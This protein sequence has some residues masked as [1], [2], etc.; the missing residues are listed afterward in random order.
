MAEKLLGF[1]V[2]ANDKIVTQILLEAGASPMA[3]F[4]LFSEDAL[5]AAIKLN[6]TK[7]LPLLICA[8]ARE[9]CPIAQLAFEEVEEVPPKRLVKLSLETSQPHVAMKLLKHYHPPSSDNVLF[10]RF[11]NV[12]LL[13][14]ALENCDAEIVELVLNYEAGRKFQLVLQNIERIK[15]AGCGGFRK[16]LPYAA[17]SGNRQLVEEL[18]SQGAQ[19]DDTT[20]SGMSC[21]QVVDMNDLP[22]VQYLLDCGAN[23]NSTDMGCGTPLHYAARSGN[24]AA[25]KLL[26]DHGAKLGAIS[27]SLCSQDSLVRDAIRS[28]NVAVVEEIL[29][30]GAVADVWINEPCATPLQLASYQGSIDIVMLLLSHNANINSPPG[31]WLAQP[32]KCGFT[33]LTGALH[34]RDI[35]LISYLL[36][37]GADVNNPPA[38]HEAPSPL[39]TCIE[40][41][42][43]NMTV[44]LLRRGANP[45]DSGSIWTAVRKADLGIVNLLLDQNRKLLS[46]NRLSQGAGFTDYGCAALCEAVLRG[47][48]ELVCTLLEAGV[49]FKRPPT[50]IFHQ[51]IIVASRVNF[52]ESPSMSAILAA[53]KTMNLNLLQMFLSQGSHNLRENLHGNSELLL[54]MHS[55]PCEHKDV[56]QILKL[57]NPTVH[58]VN[59]YCPY[60]KDQASTILQKAIRNGCCLSVVNYLLSIGADINSPAV[61]KFGRTALQ[62]AV[63]RNR[64]DIVE[65]LIHK[66][67]FINADPAV[68]GGATALQLAAM[69]GNFK[70]VQLLLDAGADVL[71]PKGKRYGRT[72]IEGAAERGHLDMVLYLLHLANDVEGVDFEH[73]LCRA[74]RLALNRGHIALSEVISEHQKDK[75]GRLHCEGIERL[76]TCFDYGT[77][78][79]L[80]RGSEYSEDDNKW[81]ETGVPI[82]SSANSSLLI[83]GLNINGM[84]EFEEKDLSTNHDSQNIYNI[85]IH[86]NCLKT[87]GEEAMQY[88]IT[89]NHQIAAENDSS[90][91]DSTITLN[92]ERNN[93]LMLGSDPVPTDY[94]AD[95][96]DIPGSM[97]TPQWDESEVTEKCQTA[98]DNDPN[99]SGSAKTS[100]QER[101]KNPDTTIVDTNPLPNDYL[102]DFVDIPG[103]MSTLQWNEFDIFEDLNMSEQATR[104]RLL[105]G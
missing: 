22:M 14:Y 59:S 71:A 78:A 73:Q 55:I 85:P 43:Y 17:R 70:I 3:L 67:A 93:D 23:P 88:E 69:I 15:N 86:S 21:L 96:H 104:E 50:R 37:H 26:F 63:E 77:F 45:E 53:I 31:K 11:Y 48:Y 10:H 66:G 75:F 18:L 101:E 100:N 13:C 54:A 56:L 44:Q 35:Q 105:L 38:E 12:S 42:D 29:K 32:F 81:S 47:K 6:R 25:V 4:G 19:I 60:L 36:D 76:G 51:A 27:G 98:T 82:T 95:F 34:S 1:A 92:Q 39:Q 68:E 87:L 61:G 8:G 40:F 5:S 33:A 58:E 84:P 57:I 97:A 46:Q 9:D 2:R 65:I 16:C 74:S 90:L 94:L 49:D 62:A 7:L 28:G 89:E 72:A 41:L 30:V 83:R 64:D 24:L 20:S 99:L 79:E 80:D 102:P 52:F 103:S 91:T